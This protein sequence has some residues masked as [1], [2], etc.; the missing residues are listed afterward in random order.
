MSWV[1][2]GNA[3]YTKTRGEL[4]LNKNLGDGFYAFYYKPEN[5]SEACDNMISL[6]TENSS[7]AFSRMEALKIM[8]DDALSSLKIF[9][10]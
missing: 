7:I 4:W 2:V 8:S 3:V 9:K 1:T 6:N 10:G 5:S